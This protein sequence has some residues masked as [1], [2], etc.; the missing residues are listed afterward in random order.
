MCIS[1]LKFRKIGSHFT[2]ASARN[3]QMVTTTF[4][5][6]QMLLS[7]WGIADMVHPAISDILKAAVLNGIDMATC[8]LVP[9]SATSPVKNYKSPCRWFLLFSPKIWDKKLAILTQQS[10]FYSKN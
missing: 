5:G 2:H 7:G 9:G 1:F 8:G 10:A 4:V 6:D 3:R